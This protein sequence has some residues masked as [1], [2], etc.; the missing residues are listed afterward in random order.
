MEE[1]WLEA[2]DK[3][4]SFLYTISPTLPHTICVTGDSFRTQSI[5]KG[6]R[7]DMENSSGHVVVPITPD[8]GVREPYAV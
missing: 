1:L 3:D 4:S 2:S 8:L 6:G 7:L 5:R